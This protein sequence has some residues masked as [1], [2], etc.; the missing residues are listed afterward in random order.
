MNGPGTVGT[1]RIESALVIIRGGRQPLL[2]IRMKSKDG[3]LRFVPGRR[4]KPL[5][6]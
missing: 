2:E 6:N 1:G 5:P 4:N 3:H